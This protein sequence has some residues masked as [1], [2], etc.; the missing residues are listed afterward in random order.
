ML[1]GTFGI[2]VI[3]LS[4]DTAACKEIHELVPAAECAEVKQGVSRTTA[5]SLSHPASRA[6]IHDKARRAIERLAEFKP[7]PTSGPVEVKVQLTTKGTTIMDPA[8]GVEQVD[9]RTWVFRG[10]DIIEAWS[11]YSSF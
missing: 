4:G 1:A 11:K 10:K 8:P 9:E 7:Y 5:Y 6:L 3:M 2:P